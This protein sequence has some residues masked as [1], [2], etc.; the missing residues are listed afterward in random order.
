MGQG[1]HCLGGSPG[2]HRPYLLRAPLTKIGSDKF[3]IPGEYYHGGGEIHG[4]HKGIHRADAK[5]KE[6]KVPGG[7]TV[8]APR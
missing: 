1:P 7:G 5:P 6:A 2:R 4:D 8:E 3:E